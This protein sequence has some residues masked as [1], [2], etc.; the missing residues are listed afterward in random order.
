MATGNVFS[1][2][3]LNH[4]FGSP[5][6]SNTLNSCTHLELKIKPVAAKSKGFIPTIIMATS[7]N[8][9]SSRI[10][11]A[12]ESRLSLLFALATQAASQ[13][14]RLIQDLVSET[15]KYISPRRFEARS[16]EEALMAVPDL[17]TVPFK[18]LRREK[19]Y[20][21]REVQAFYV[22]ETTM[23]GKTGFDF[24]GSSQGF[25]ALAAY[26]FG[27]NKKNEEMEMTTPVFVQKAQ[28]DG[29]KMEMTT[30]VITKQEQDQ[31]KWQMSFVMPSKYGAN[32]PIPSDP[33]I[34]IKKITEKVVAVIAFSGF[35]TD[36]E[37][38]RRES[39]LRAALSKDPQ[40]HVKENATVEVAQEV[41]NFEQEDEFVYENMDQL[42]AEVNA[43]EYALHNEGLNDCPKPAEMEKLDEWKGGK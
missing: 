2:S 28:I 5:A 27:K 15:F 26:L 39:Q 33:S 42:Q 41:L 22:A 8:N 10:V 13:S 25:N 30:P 37:V 23:P 11:S 36:E 38:Q 3:V 17:E 6:S 14:Q 35:V 16:L 21:I 7:S 20:E 12:D 29:E 40:V 31:G 18:V 34:R 43:L 32:L 9:S 1:T 4:G 24:Y 19:D